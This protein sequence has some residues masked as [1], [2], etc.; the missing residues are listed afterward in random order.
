M[1]LIMA[2]IDFDGN[3]ITK[4]YTRWDDYHADTFCPDYETLWLTDFK[5][6]GKNYAER[7]ACAEDIGISF[8]HAMG[9]WYPSWMELAEVTGKLENIAKRYGL[10]K[11]FKENALI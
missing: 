5:V 9:T 11:E 1:G 7:K 8:S 6:R 2:E 4:T 3:V 10:V